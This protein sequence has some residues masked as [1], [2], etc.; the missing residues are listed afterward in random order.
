[1][2][3]MTL[4]E[5]SCLP[6]TQP[7]GITVDAV[8]VDALEEQEQDPLDVILTDAQFP[9]NG[10]KNVMPNT[11]NQ[12]INVTTNT[13]KTWPMSNNRSKTYQGRAISN[14]KTSKLFCNHISNNQ[15]S[16]I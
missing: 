11:R 1:M 16:N 6:C 2:K 14:C 3:T 12:T 8:V 4:R 7:T 5:V 10:V 13:C 15:I 9:A